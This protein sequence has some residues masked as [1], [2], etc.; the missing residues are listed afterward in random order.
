MLGFAN[1]LPGRFEQGKKSLDVSRPDARARVF[2]GGTFKAYTLFTW[3]RIDRLSQ[4]YNALFMGDNYNNGEPHWQINE[5]GK[6]MISVMVNEKL[7]GKG[8][9][10]K[11]YWTEP[12]WN[13][14]LSGKWIQLASTYDPIKKEVAS[15]FNGERIAHE[16]IADEFFIENLKIGGA[17][18]GSWGLP[19]KADDKR[20]SI[21]NLNGRIDELMIFDTALSADEIKKLYEKGRPD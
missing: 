13:D 4:Q 19:F 11:I 16:K 21:R 9:Y 8:R 12:F 20:F 10:H 15:Y 18:I 1:S 2:V 17:E 6:L 14:S 7:R 5:E 3:V